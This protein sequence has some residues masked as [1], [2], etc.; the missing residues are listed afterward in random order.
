MKPAMKALIGLVVVGVV[1]YGINVVM[2]NMEARKIITQQEVPPPVQQTP[3]A[4]QIVQQAQ[5]IVRPVQEPIQQ[6][7]VQEPIQQAPQPVQEPQ[8]SAQ[9]ESDAGL[10]A[11]MQSGRK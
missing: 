2:D 7:P 11:L 3:Q 6:A 1:G 4:Q 8:H 9:Q 5:Q 10:S